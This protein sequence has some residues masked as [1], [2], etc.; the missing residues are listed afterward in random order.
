M[1]PIGK[2]SNWELSGVHLT[3][4]GVRDLVEIAKTKQW[5]EIFPGVDEI[6]TTEEAHLKPKREEKGHSEAIGTRSVS[7]GNREDSQ[8]GRPEGIGTSFVSKSN[9]EEI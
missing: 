8:K 9:R 4:D 3:V 1:D 6:R 7:K 5:R 2:L